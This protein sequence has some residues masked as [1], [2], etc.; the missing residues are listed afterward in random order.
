MTFVHAFAEVVL[1][2]VVSQQGDTLNRLT[3]FTGHV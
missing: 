3:F 2:P 1:L